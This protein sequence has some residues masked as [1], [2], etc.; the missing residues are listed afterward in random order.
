MGDA[1]DQDVAQ[2][3][4]VDGFTLKFIFVNIIILNK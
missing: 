4:R 2:N 1:L 3:V